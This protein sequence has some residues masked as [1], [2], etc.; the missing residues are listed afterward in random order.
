MKF[1]DKYEF[2]RI[3][4]I[5]VNNQYFAGNNRFFVYVDMDEEKIRG[6]INDEL[7]EQAVEQYIN[8]NYSELTKPLLLQKDAKNKK[9]HTDVTAKAAVKKQIIHQYFV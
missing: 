9:K 4:E 2:M 3:A 1:P 8:E 5:M 6:G 7:I